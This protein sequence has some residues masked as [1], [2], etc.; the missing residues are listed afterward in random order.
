MNAIDEERLLQGARDRELEALDLCLVGVGYVNREACAAK[1][2]GDGG[3]RACVRSADHITLSDALAKSLR[4]LLQQAVRI[5]DADRIAD[6]PEPVQP[7]HDDLGLSQSGAQRRSQL[8]RCRVA[9]HRAPC[10][11]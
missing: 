2:C 10:G 6:H 9:S 1:P 5:I 8:P 11:P 7:D 4:E 3:H